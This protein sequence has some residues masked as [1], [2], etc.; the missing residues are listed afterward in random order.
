MTARRIL[1]IATFFWCFLIVATPIFASFGGNSALAASV[2]YEMFSRVCHQMDSRSFHV[3][4]FK[5]GVCIR[6]TAIYASFF[7]GMLL[8]PL[9]KRTVI[10]LQNP[11]FILIISLIPMGIDV[12]LAAVGIHES[13]SYTRMATG[14]LFGCALSI[15][16]VPTLEE[17]TG[18]IFSSLQVPQRVSFNTKSAQSAIGDKSAQSA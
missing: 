2:F 13:N 12:G 4:G 18:Q 9:L 14:A 1:L 11:S 3:A 5:F 10:A 17:V 15:I 7:G 16:L 6:C 8:F